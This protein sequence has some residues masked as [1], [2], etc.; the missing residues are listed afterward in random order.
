MR[1][2]LL[3]VVLVGV[4]ALALFEIGRLLFAFGQAG[5]EPEYEAWE[6]LTG[7]VAMLTAFAL[8]VGITRVPATWHRVALAFVV[9]LGVLLVAALLISGLGVVLLAFADL[10]EKLGGVAEPYAVAAALLVSVGILAGGTLLAR[11]GSASRTS[12]P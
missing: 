9:P 8:A 5:V 12:G 1:G 4:A 6:P 10:R 2:L 3:A 11:R 7:V